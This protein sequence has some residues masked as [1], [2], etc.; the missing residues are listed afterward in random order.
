MN[1][2]LYDTLDGITKE[3]SVLDKGYVRIVDV[4]P[5]LVPEDHTADYAIAE[6]ARVSYGY[7]TKKVSDDEGLIRYL[8]R[9]KH[10]SC[11]EMCELKFN[12]KIPLF[13]FGQMVRHRTAN[14]NQESARYSIIKD[15][16]YIPDESNVRAQS[17]SNKQGSEG[18]VEKDNALFFIEDVFDTCKDNYDKYESAIS[19]NV[20]KEQ[21]RMLL[22]QNIYTN[23]YWK[24]DLHNILH[25]L[26]LRLD[27]HAQWEIRQ[28]AEAIYKF[29]SDIFPITAKAFNDY[30]IN[31]IRLTAFDV[32]AIKTGV[33]PG[34]NKREI[35]EWESKKKLL[36]V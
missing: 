31:S 12:I 35:A 6:A 26:R 14:I 33:F 21:A 17:M 29:V 7:G 13:V 20:T 24:C 8:L 27:H 32:E 36:G 18:L 9:N 34:N 15:E 16:F 30:D 4:M 22:P 1:V 5:R 19:A 28:Y 25:F 11:F 2:K 3:I 23:L 10:T